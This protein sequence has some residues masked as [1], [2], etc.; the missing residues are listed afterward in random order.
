MV[1]GTLRLLVGEASVVAVAVVDNL[2]LVQPPLS[3]PASLL[4]SLVIPGSLWDRGGG[5]LCY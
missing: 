5:R 1:A 2:V 3:V 4:A